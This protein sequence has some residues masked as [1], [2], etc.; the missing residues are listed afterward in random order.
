VP[1]PATSVSRAAEPC[2]MKWCPACCVARLLCFK[3]IK[4]LI[5]SALVRNKAAASSPQVLAW[6][7]K[8]VRPVLVN[9]RKGGIAAQEQQVRASSHA[10]LMQHQQPACPSA[11]TLQPQHS[12]SSR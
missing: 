11:S 8:V 1:D 6:L 12:N 5:T 4:Y 9:A 7:E 2:L 10:S 3:C